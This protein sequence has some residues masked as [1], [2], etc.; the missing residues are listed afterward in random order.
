MASE[1]GVV[2][3]EEI[4]HYGFSKAAQLAIARGCAELTKGTSVT[5]NSVLPGPTWVEEMEAN[6]IKRAA[7]R[8]TTVEA[9][10]KQ[11]F[12]ERRTSSLIQ[13]FE[14]A[15]E[16]ASMICYVCSPAA[17][18]TNGAGLRCDGGIIRIP[19]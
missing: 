12:S 18:G 13:R 10:Q 16:I 8:G 14:T 4:I 5:V 7:A 15:E 19:F 3:P 17:S 1:F 9:L 6:F 11:M 2:V